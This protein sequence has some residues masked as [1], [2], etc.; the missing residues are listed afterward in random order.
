MKKEE[1]AMPIETDFTNL[2]KHID[3]ASDG[4][5]QKVESTEEELDTLN[6]LLT[7]K[8]ELVDKIN[9]LAEEIED[10]LNDANSLI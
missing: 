8:K 7:R 6:T 4:L 1:R 3:D 9:S 2:L 10:F 5:E